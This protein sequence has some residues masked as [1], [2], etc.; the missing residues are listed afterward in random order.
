MNIKDREA[1]KKL[2][3]ELRVPQAQA[4]S[5]HPDYED[6]I[7]YGRDDAADQI[8]YLIKQLDAPK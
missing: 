8:E 1:F 7:D 5:S 6:G 2:I 3:A 4:Y